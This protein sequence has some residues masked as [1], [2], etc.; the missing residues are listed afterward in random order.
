MNSIKIR[1]ATADGVEKEENMCNEVIT[2]ECIYALINIIG[3][4]L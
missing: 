4:F 2:E 3:I 1:R